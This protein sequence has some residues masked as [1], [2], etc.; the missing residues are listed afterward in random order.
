MALQWGKESNRVREREGERE[1]RECELLYVN[2]THKVTKK[3]YRE[4]FEKKRE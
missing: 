1:R 3:C 4:T 2:T